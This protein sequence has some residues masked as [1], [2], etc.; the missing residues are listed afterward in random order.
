MNVVEQQQYRLPARKTFDLPQ[1]RLER[2][3]LLTLRREIELWSEVSQ[4]QRQK[5]RDQRN[6]FRHF[7]IDDADGCSWIAHIHNGKRGHDATIYRP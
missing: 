4:W 7:G 2:L 1:Q 6:I 3:L 5:F